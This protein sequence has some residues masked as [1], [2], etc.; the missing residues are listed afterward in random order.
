MPRAGVQENCD[1]VNNDQNCHDAGLLLTTNDVNLIS[2]VLTEQMVI[3]EIP[4]VYHS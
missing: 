2:Y 4:E 3:G 1:R